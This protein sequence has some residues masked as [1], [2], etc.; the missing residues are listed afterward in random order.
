MAIMRN[1]TRTTQQ[2]IDSPTASYTFGIGGSGACPTQKPVALLEWLIRTYSNEGDIVLDP[3]MG[4]GT[5]G[6][7]CANTGREFIG[8]E[9]D[10]GYFATARRRMG[11][12]ERAAC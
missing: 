8:I 12:E 5:T 9:L 6:V 4:S 7:A 10:P 3:T 1:R 11:Q 2:G